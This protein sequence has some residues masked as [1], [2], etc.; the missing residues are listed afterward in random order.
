[1]AVMQLTLPVEGMTCASCVNHVERALRKVAGV[2]EASVNLAT[3][4]ASVA[5]DPQAA[6]LTDLVRAVHDAGYDVPTE[7]IA[8]PIGG[9]TCA[10]CVRHVERALGKV[11]GVASVGVNLATEKATVTYLPAAAGLP[12]LRQAVAAAGYEVLDTAEEAAAGE[13]EENRRGR[14]QDACVPLPDARRLGPLRGRLSCG[15]SP[16]C[17]SAS[18]GPIRRSTTWA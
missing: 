6:A 2:A 10:S 7:T 1:M 4:R 18:F 14:A 8:L 16:R 12:E 13:G 11:G 9:M 17:S 5:F 15:C 3:E